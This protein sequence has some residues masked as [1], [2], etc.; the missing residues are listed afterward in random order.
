MDRLIIELISLFA[1][2]SLIRLY[3]VN[4]KLNFAVGNHFESKLKTRYQEFIWLTDTQSYPNAYWGIIPVDISVI[5]TLTYARDFIRDLFQEKDDRIISLATFCNH[6][7]RRL[8]CRNIAR[9]ELLKYD[10]CT[11]C[12]L[13][14]PQLLEANKT[15]VCEFGCVVTCCSTINA[16]LHMED[17][18]NVR[19]SNKNDTKLHS[20]YG[21]NDI[22]LECGHYITYNTPTKILSE[23]SNGEKKCSCGT[24]ITSTIIKCNNCNKIPLISNRNKHRKRSQ[25]NDY[26]K[27]KN[28]YL[29]LS[30]IQI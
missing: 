1:D 4:K 5:N 23:N 30:K 6:Y 16:I 20:L 17:G 2:S 28:K 21:K 22:E 13:F 26:L 8:S 7:M 14:G 3:V 10:Y 15:K 27:Y 25:Y 19:C 18:Y 11:D 9:I 29:S 24:V 12:H